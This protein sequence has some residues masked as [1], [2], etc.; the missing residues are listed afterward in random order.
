MKLYKLTDKNNQTQ[1]GTTWGEGVTHTAMGKSTQLCTNDVIHAYESPLLAVLLN[2]VH[3]RFA[4]PVLWEAEGDICARAGQLKCGTKSLTTLR[5]IELPVF[6]TE[7]RV[8]FAIACAWIGA[9]PDWCT[10][11]SNWLTGKDRTAA[12]AAAKAAKAASRE[13]AWAA[14]AA[15]EVAAE[16]AAAAREA[17]RE[18]AAAAAWA[19]AEAAAREA[20][21]R[22]AWAAREVAASRTAWVAEAAAEAAT[23]VASREAARLDLH[24]LAA[25]A[26]TDSVEVPG[27]K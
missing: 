9:S 18:V 6:T 22:A 16:A 19:C 13:A 27:S 5:R 1:G 2:P 17:A 25:W 10:W 7:Q 4:D 26:L 21:S 8:R 24:V 15:R 12:A 23:W 11:G 3:A 20:A 14:E